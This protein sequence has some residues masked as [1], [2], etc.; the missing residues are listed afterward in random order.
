ML[1]NL[2]RKRPKGFSEYYFSCYKYRAF[3]Y[4]SIEEYE[5]VTWDISKLE[6]ES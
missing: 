3:G 5:K 4:A 1:T 6:R 2:I